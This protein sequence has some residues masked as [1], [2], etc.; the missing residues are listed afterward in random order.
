M[1]DIKDDSE[2]LSAGWI[3]VKP[4]YRALEGRSCRGLLGFI[5]LQNEIQ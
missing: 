4:V 5:Y 1:K 3:N 2:S